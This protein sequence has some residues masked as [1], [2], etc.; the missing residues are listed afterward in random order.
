VST[1]EIERTLRQAA[2]LRARVEQLERE[3][4][5]AHR[6]LSVM[7]TGLATLVVILLFLD[8]WLAYGVFRPGS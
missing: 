2:R 3:E 5:L 8:G 7:T 1:T 6:V 4:R